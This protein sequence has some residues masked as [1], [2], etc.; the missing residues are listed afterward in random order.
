MRYISSTMV[1]VTPDEAATHL[2]DLIARARRGE[3]I[4]I[5][6]GGQ[7]VQLVPVATPSDAP[8]RISTRRSQTSRTTCH[9]AARRYPRYDVR[10][11]G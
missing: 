1:Q 10:R 2:D 8:R 11:I 6:S 7:A 9:E 3:A 5:V 4:V